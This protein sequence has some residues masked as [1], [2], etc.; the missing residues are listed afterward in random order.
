MVEK[1]NRARWPQTLADIR[2]EITT[3]DA[4]FANVCVGFCNR[5]FQSWRE[6]NHVRDTMAGGNQIAVRAARDFVPPNIA[7]K[8]AVHFQRQLRPAHLRERIA[9]ARQRERTA[10]V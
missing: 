6:R 10:E 2:A 4:D 9:V 5:S 1:L 7:I 3:D 8:F